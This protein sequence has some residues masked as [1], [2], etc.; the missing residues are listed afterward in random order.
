MSHLGSVR[1]SSTGLIAILVVLSLAL[2]GA[3]AGTASAARPGQLHAHA[4][5]VKVTSLVTGRTA[6]GLAVR[7]KF[8]PKRFVVS[9]GQ[10]F[11]KGI[12]KGRIIKPGKDARFRRGASMAVRAIDGH[13]TPAGNARSAAA[14]A[15]PPS[16]APG[17]C[18]VLNL[19][20]A[21]LD[22]NILG[23]QVHL[24]QVVLNVV[25]QS[26]AGQLLGNLLC[27]VAGLLDGGGPL[28]GLLTQVQGLLNR[29]LGS[30]GALRA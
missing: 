18:N 22:L 1:R 8:I 2:V 6:S 12:L 7:A 4:K 24:N 14:A 19:V 25:A 20:L 9:D 15:F 26:G 21:P 28:S 13:G 10:M 30:L 29:I 3:S 5:H 27:F 11:A 23:L 16:P 17:A